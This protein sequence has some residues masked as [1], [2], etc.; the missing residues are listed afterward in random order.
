MPGIVVPDQGQLELA[1][2]C[3]CANPSPGFLYL[4]DLFQNQYTPD[5]STTF[6]NFTLCDFMGYAQVSFPRSKMV[7]PITIGHQAQ[8]AYLANPVS[9]NNNGPQQAVWGFLV[10]SNVTGNVLWC[11]AYNSVQLVGLGKQL[12]FDLTLNV[13]GSNP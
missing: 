7:A 5:Q 1:S 2:Y 4:V 11:Q 9:W 13:F 8:V 10:R 6:A 12:Q 3:L